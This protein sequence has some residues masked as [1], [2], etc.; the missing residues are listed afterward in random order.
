VVLQQVAKGFACGFSHGGA[1]F[2]SIV[3]AF[4]CAVHEP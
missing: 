4:Q 3:S 1:G 2:H